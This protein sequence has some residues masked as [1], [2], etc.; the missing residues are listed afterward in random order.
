MSLSYISLQLM[1]SLLILVDV[2]ECS[3]KS[4]SGYRPHLE[5]YW[6]IC[7]DAT[8]CFHGGRAISE[9]KQIYNYLAFHIL[10]NRLKLAVICT[11]DNAAIAKIVTTQ[12]LRLPRLKECSIRLGDKHNKDL[13]CLAK[14]TAINA[15]YRSIKLRPSIFR[16]MDLPSELQLR[17]LEFT[18]LVTPWDLAWY[19]PP[20][21]SVDKAGTSTGLYFEFRRFTK[22]EGIG[23]SMYCYNRAKNFIY[24]SVTDRT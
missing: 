12:I 13:F 16:F 21:S 17:V 14:E 20:G 1:T 5:H 9:W 22:C 18:D 3:F 8:S 15:I 23:L 24:D 19:I 11:T 4:I 6:D 10:P 7:F 2:P